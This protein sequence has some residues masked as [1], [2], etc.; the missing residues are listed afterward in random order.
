MTKQVN[1]F[2]NG[3]RT[4]GRSGRTHAL[5]N[6]ATKDYKCLFANLPIGLMNGG[7]RQTG[8]KIIHVMVTCMGAQEFASRTSVV[9]SGGNI[10]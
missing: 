1:H 8:R 3:R 9:R 2:V 10:P 5:V 7:R 4:A 6:P